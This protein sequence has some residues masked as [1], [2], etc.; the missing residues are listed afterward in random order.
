MTQLNTRTLYTILNHCTVNHTEVLMFPCFR[1]CE[2]LDHKSVSDA[3][4]MFSDV[5]S[6]LTEVV[7]AA[8]SVLVV[9]VFP[10]G[11]GIVFDFSFECSNKNTT[12]HNIDNNIAPYTNKSYHTIHIIKPTKRQ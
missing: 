6:E 4:L 12:E 2:Q 5:I 1:I 7:V 3:E 9:V 11:L 10:V 8:K